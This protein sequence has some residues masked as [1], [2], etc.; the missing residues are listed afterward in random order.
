VSGIEE[1]LHGGADNVG[2]VVR[3]GNT[4][5]RPVSERAPLTHAFL[6]HLEQQG[7]EGAPRL[8][9]VDP[10]GREILDFVPGKVAT[11]PYPAWVANEDLLVSVAQLQRRLHEAARDFQVEPQ[12]EPIARRAQGSLAEYDGPLMC[13][14]DVCES[15]VVVRD[16]RAVAFIDF[17]LAAPCDPVFDIAMAAHY[18]VPL[19]D[20]ADLDHSRAHLTSDDLVRRFHRYLEVFGLADDERHRVIRCHQTWCERII[21]GMRRQ[22][23]SGH[24]GF[25]QIWEAGFEAR[26]RRQIAWVDANRAALVN[27]RWSVGADRAGPCDAGPPP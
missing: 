10:K 11:E 9:G 16:G 22:A 21:P 25:K 12:H 24:A 15:N 18:W 20:P 4:V 14:Q 19:R 17:D 7:F 23:Q 8:H 1:T 27:P 3:I 5:R 26:V 13:H 6:R 2:A